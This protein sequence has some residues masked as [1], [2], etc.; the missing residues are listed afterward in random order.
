MQDYQEYTKEELIMQMTSL[1]R[2]NKELLQTIQESERLEFGWTGNLGQWFWDFT[3]NEV[4][5]NPLKAEAIGY[6]K[7]DLPEKVPYQFF[8]DK[9]HPED[10]DEV[11]QQMTNH[12]TG[13]TPVWE[14]K[15]RIQAKDGSWKVY[16]DRGKVTER[17]EKNEP[18]FLKGIVFDITQEEQERELLKVKNKNLTSRMKIDTLTSLRTRSS[19]I[20]ELV[21]HANRSK[22]EDIPLSVMVLNVDNYAKYEEDFGIV[23]SEEIL[24]IVGQV[25]KAATED[26]YVAGRY[27]DSVFLILLENTQIEE[28]LILA[29]TIKQIVLE[30]VFD[31][32]HH[33]TI[34]GGISTFQSEEAI[35]ELIQKVAKKLVAAQK[36]GGNQIVI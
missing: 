35:S 21:K 16:Q 9:V 17:N 30:T 14:V 7:E 18:L 31:V 5:F 34:S 8:T 10:K 3:T 32:P 12:L 15:Y 36:N 26:K 25:I 6:M 4:T 27:R 11:M 2:L 1:T 22:K 29:E 13:K 28:A 23:L 20:V 24:K 33:I 19:I